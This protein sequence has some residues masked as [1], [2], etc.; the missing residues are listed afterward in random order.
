MAQLCT[1]M[2]IRHLSGTPYS[3]WTNGLVEVQKNSLGTHIRV[4][5]QNTSKYWAYQVHIYSYA[6][7]SQPGSSLN[8]SPHKSV[9]HTC[10]RIPLTFDLNLNR[11]ANK[12]CIPKYC[13]ELPEHSLYNKTYLNPLS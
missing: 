2:G 1:L 12:T 13:F 11:V 9:S 3:P 10:P 5:L 6:H 7:N 4:F 8:V